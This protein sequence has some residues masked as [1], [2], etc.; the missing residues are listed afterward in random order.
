MPHESGTRP[1]QTTERSN[2]HFTNETACVQ[3]QL[4]SLVPE[5]FGNWGVRN[6]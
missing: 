5:I 4:L 6:I 1:Q 3:L 2:S